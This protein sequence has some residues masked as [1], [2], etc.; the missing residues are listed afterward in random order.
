MLEMIDGTPQSCLSGAFE[1]LHL[2]STDAAVLHEEGDCH[3]TRMLFC[4]ES[5]EED[6]VHVPLGPKQSAL[7]LPGWLRERADTLTSADWARLCEVGV[8]AATQH[9]RED[10]EMPMLDLYATD[11]GFCW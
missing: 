6:A 3:L 7:V 10:C 5:M 8:A 1:L 2:G 9:E 11:E 4:H